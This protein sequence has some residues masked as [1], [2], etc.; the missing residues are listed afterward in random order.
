MGCGAS[1]QMAQGQTTT[2]SVAAVAPA[3]DKGASGKGHVQQQSSASNPAHKTTAQKARSPTTEQTANGSQLQVD[4]ESPGLVS[5]IL[6]TRT[7]ASTTAIRG[8]SQSD[9]KVRDSNAAIK[10][11]HAG[12]SPG[13]SHSPTTEMDRPSAHATSAKHDHQDDPLVPPAAQGESPHKEV[14]RSAYLAMQSNMVEDTS[15]SG[16]SNPQLSPKSKDAG[17]HGGSTAAI[18]TQ[19][20]TALAMNTALP[21]SRNDLAMSTASVHQQLSGNNAK[22]AKSQSIN[23]L[24]SPAAGVAQSH[25]VLAM[26]TALPS[27]RNDLL[28]S[29]ASVAGHAAPSDIPKKSQSVQQLSSRTQLSGGTGDSKNAVLSTTALAMNTALPH[30]NANLLSHESVSPQHEVADMKG[31][32]ALPGGSNT[33]ISKITSGSQHSLTDGLISHETTVPEHEVADAKGH[34]AL[35]G[36]SNTVLAKVK[37][38]SIHSLKDGDTHRA[39]VDVANSEGPVQMAQKSYSRSGSRASLA[40]ALDTV[41]EV[42]S[43]TSPSSDQPGVTKALSE[44]NVAGGFVLSVEETPQEKVIEPV[45]SDAV[46]WEIARTRPLPASTNELSKIDEHHD[47]PQAQEQQPSAATKP[48][49]AVSVTELASSAGGRANGSV[50]KAESRGDVLDVATR[51]PLPPSTYELADSHSHVVKKAESKADALEM[52]A[53]KPL[54]ASTYDLATNGSNR[55][56]RADVSGAARRPPS[57]GMAGSPT[58]SKKDGGSR[59]SSTGSHKKIGSNPRVSDLGQNPGSRKGSAGSATRKGSRPASGAHA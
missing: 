48:K 27:S 21:A 12:I 31:H 33:N 29:Q 9:I 59:P 4:V 11:S 42:A 32:T 23:N 54:P 41:T 37:S 6:L 55:G 36:G 52:A 20:N 26:N 40:P 34:T 53:R 45:M 39:P 8:G 15:P 22:K 13:L 18:K 14:S 58:A 35:P 19:S 43:P 25:T 1:K 56:S 50:K 7:A 49:K 17:G 38:G 51:K 2:R 28:K 10:S 24:T 16:R 46:A 44:P 47:S 5:R 3:D 57:G 30:S